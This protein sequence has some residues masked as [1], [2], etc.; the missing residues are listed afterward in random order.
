[1]WAPA[2]T[3]RGMYPPTSRR[4][5]PARPRR[6]AGPGT[7]GKPAVAPVSARP[8]F[9]WMASAVH[10]PAGKP[11][12]RATSPARLANAR[13]SPRVLD[14]RIHR[15]AP[16]ARQPRAASTV[17]ATARAAVVS[18]CEVPNARQATARAIPSRASALATAKA[19]VPRPNLSLVR[20]TPAIPRPTSVPAGV[21]PTSS[22]R[23]G[24]NAF[25][26]RAAKASTARTATTTT[27]A[28]RV[29]AWTT[30]AAT[31]LAVGRACLAVRPA[32]SAIARTSPS[33][34]LIP[35]AMGRT[36]PPAVGPAFATGQADAH[37]SARTR[38]ANRP[39]AL[40]C[41]RT[42]PGPVTAV[43]PVEIPNSSIARPSSVL[44]ARANPVAISR[45]RM[46]ASPAT[47][48]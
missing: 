31:S 41:S 13:R 8:D 21:R 28:C 24:T 4:L 33:T 37:F 14:R 7:R 15:R 26:V 34:G 44:T 17:R 1:M 18:T 43:A 38:C 48:A 25:P 2:K 10:R 5:A 30:S 46:S 11:A 20:P 23:P 6:P 29:S 45:A 36:P 47:P 40:A 16:P 35:T 42:R 32:R 22:A 12:W 9:A 19:S 3:A 39:T 27:D